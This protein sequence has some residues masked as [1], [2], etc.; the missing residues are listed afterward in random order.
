[1][2]D[3]LDSDFFF[4]CREVAPRVPIGAVVHTL[5]GEVKKEGCCPT[6][7]GGCRTEQNV[8]TLFEGGIQ[9]QSMDT[10]CFGLYS[11]NISRR[12]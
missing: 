5:K 12:C 10:D 3:C 6:I 7:T 4:I 11:Y 2:D 8:L 9:A 1:M